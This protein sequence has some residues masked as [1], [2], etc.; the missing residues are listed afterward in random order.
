M[1]R[2]P[3]GSAY[4]PDRRAE[5]CRPAHTHRGKVHGHCAL[6]GP[7][8]PQGRVEGHRLLSEPRR[9]EIRD[10]ASAL[11]AD[12][13]RA[14]GTGHARPRRKQTGPAKTC[15]RLTEMTDL[16][17]LAEEFVSLTG[18]IAAIK[19]SMRKIL[20]NGVD[21]HSS[22]PH[23]ARPTRARR[24]G[25]K[26]KSRR[27]PRKKPH[28]HHPNAI[29]AETI[30]AH[31]LE[32]LQAKPGLRTAELARLTG[33]PPTSTSNRLARMLAKSQAARDGE[34]WSASAPS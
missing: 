16:V 12:G 2:R 9:G 18:R 14:A 11:H 17:Q 5:A 7:H 6:D 26:K 23:P 1:L 4:R 27:S 15:S 25:G 10:E 21:V 29:R 32:L 34:G 13:S 20:A 22:D 30:E 31:I 28:A 19:D 3:E 33:S 24:L 8:V